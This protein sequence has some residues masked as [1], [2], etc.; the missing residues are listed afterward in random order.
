MPKSV[1]NNVQIEEFFVKIRVCMWFNP[2][3]E[4]IAKQT[5]RLFFSKYQNSK[6]PIQKYTKIQRKKK[7]FV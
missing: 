7:S 5:Q 3:F 4:L 2:K 6:S 1:I